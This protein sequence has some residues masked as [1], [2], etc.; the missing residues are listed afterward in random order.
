MAKFMVSIDIVT[1]NADADTI[2][3][4]LG[5]PKSVS[6]HDQGD[7]RGFHDDTWE[8]TVWRVDSGLPE[9]RPLDEH[10][11]KLLA[12]V[13]PA[14]RSRASHLPVDHAA[15]LNIGV[16]FEGLTC[17]VVL[18]QEFVHRLGEANIGI[19]VTAYLSST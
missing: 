3:R 17:G 19:E 11:E 8:C 16:L 7:K 4:I 18:R 14:I 1:K 15:L 9:E 13:V 12:A 6:S 2:S 5:I 10:V